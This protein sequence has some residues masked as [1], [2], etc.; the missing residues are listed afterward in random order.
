MKS[1]NTGQIE[2][3][4]Y[5]RGNENEEYFVGDF[6]DAD[7]KINLRDVTFFI[8]KHKKNPN[9]KTLIIRPMRNQ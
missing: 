5:P 4:L 1:K 2:I 7:C 8:F 9:N 6:G 3:N